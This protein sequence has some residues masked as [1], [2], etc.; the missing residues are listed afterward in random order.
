MKTTPALV[1]LVALTF[2]AAE[3]L[4]AQRRGSSGSGS[5]ERSQPS[6][7]RGGSSSSGGSRGGSSSGGSSGGST[8][9]A[10]PSSGGSTKA[11]GSTR[12]RDGGEAR[13]TPPASD[14]NARGA[15]GSSADRRGGKIASVRGN[16]DRAVRER[17]N[18]VYVNRGV[19]VG[20]GYGYTNCW[21]CDYW[22]WYG[23]RWG[24]YHGG[25]WYPERYHH[26]THD[27]E[28]EY[29]REDVQPGQG[30]DDYPYA[31][32][33]EDASFV[34]EHAT[35]RRGYAALSGQFFADGGSD[36][37]AGRFALEG[38]RG[39][40]RG[41]LEYSGYAEP[42]AGGTDRLH[43]FRLAVGIQPRLG[44]QGYV[45]GAVGLRGLVL[46]NGGQSAGG[47]EGELGV[48][49]LPMKPIGI[50]IVGRAALMQWENTDSHF[51]ME[52]VNTTASY[53]LNRMEFQAGWHWLKVGDA[54][55][56]GGPMVGMRVWF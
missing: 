2:L 49:L 9:R 41:E 17:G 37:K 18:V 38:A 56:F 32:G 31:A 33:E 48:Q 52:E 55:A 43:T 46:N 5:G 23:R 20:Y 11:N 3:G 29:E 14:A 34:Q 51:G 12:E 8:T 50:S 54:P 10:Q 6:G 1:A 7:S 15:S 53:F 28:D 4:N 22:G 42:L 21:D 26:H 39:L 16:A 40:L 30:Y 19:Y 35:R 36:T 24:W 45:F 25:Y 47:I 13:P 27:H 44:N